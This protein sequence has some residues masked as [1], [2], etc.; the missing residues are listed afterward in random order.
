MKK[1]YVLF[2]ALTLPFIASAT[3]VHT[4]FGNGWA[5][6]MG[7]N[8]ALDVDNNFTDDV[9]INPSATELSIAP[10]YAK[11]CYVT[12][13][14]ASG[15]GM[16]F[17]LFNSGDPIGGSQGL[18]YEES[19]PAMVLDGSGPAA[20]WID[21]EERLV[22]FM[23]FDTQFFGWMRLKMDVSANT[24]I[25]MEY[26]YE[27]T[28]GMAIPAGYRGVTAISDAP[29]FTD[30]NVYPNPSSDQ[31]NFDFGQDL[32]G[33]TTLSVFNPMGQ[34]VYAENIQTGVALHRLSVAE[35]AEGTY[36]ARIENGETIEQRRITVT[37]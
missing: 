15:N 8:I 10:I 22:G 28:F 12:T 13:G 14:V 18:Y 2:T 34:L 29:V 4:D 33:T 1:L 24:L 25:I 11:G 6:P 21:G 9:Y 5:V 35:L 23:L 17:K 7:A 19:Q 27:T 36:V 31:V 3:V 16:E 37:K 32:E 20:G 26:A 30:L